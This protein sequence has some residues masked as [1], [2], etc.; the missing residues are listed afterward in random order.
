MP[1]VA[2]QKEAGVPS[3]SAW[4]HPLRYTS[5][6]VHPNPF[7]KA[8]VS[9]LIKMEVALL[10]AQYEQQLA[11]KAEAKRQK[12]E[13][14]DKEAEIDRLKK[15]LA[16]VKD[17]AKSSAIPAAA[18]SP[19]DLQCP[20]EK[21]EKWWQQ[22]DVRDLTKDVKEV[23]QKCAAVQ[24]DQTRRD[25]E[26]AVISQSLAALWKQLEAH[27]QLTMSAREDRPSQWANRSQATQLP[28]K[29][30][31]N[32]PTGAV[33]V[34]PLTFVFGGKAYQQPLPAAPVWPVHHEG[35]VF[36]PA[37]PAGVAP[38]EPED[39]KETAVERPELGTGAEGEGD[40]EEA[41][42]EQETEGVLQVAP[43]LWPLPPSSHQ[44][45]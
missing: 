27:Q 32:G 28:P 42:A 39:A 21:Q 19:P 31:R 41:E 16:A 25:G 11:A 14:K 26:V 29:T 3:T 20:P 9:A 38:A 5:Q 1:S 2:P 12:A 8:D 6:P 43:Q 45:F 10:L 18:S 35:F 33:V 40:E 17:Q 13:L 30:R 36:G 7:S 44:Q 15:E 22:R 34:P 24:V 4:R 23:V 37:A